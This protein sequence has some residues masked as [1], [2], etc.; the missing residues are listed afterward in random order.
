MDAPLAFIP[1]IPFGQ[2]LQ[3]LSTRR[4]LSPVRTRSQRQESRPHHT[5]C[6]T[7]PANLRADRETDARGFVLP[8]QG[9]VVVFQGRWP[10][11]DEAGLVES[12]Q[13]V[14]GRSAH[15]VDVTTLRRVSA[16]LFSIPRASRKARM[17]WMDVAEVRVVPD[18]Q[19]VSTQDAYR[20]PGTCDGYAPV[21][22][23]DAQEKEV[24]DAEY[25]QL[26]A[27]MVKST[28]IAAVV[29]SIL[30]ILASRLDV[31]FAYA[32]GASASLLYLVLLQ[33]AVDSVGEQS[34]LASRFLLLRFAVPA[35]PFVALSLLHLGVPSSPG[36]FLS[37]L[38]KPEA[39][40]IVIGLLTYKVPIISRTASE[41]VDGLADI[42]LGKTGMLGTAAA[43][44]A[45]QLQKKRDGSDDDS[46]DALPIFNP[47][48]I[49]GGPSGSGKGT[50][51]ALLFEQN[52]DRFAFSVSHT[53][54][55][56]REGEVNDR[57][58]SFV[59]I[60][61]FEQMIQDGKFIEYA[62]VHGQYY[63]TSIAAVEK[64]RA[65]NRV[66]VLDVDVQ[67]IE[68]I[69]NAPSLE[70]DARF[71]WVAPPSLDALEERLRKRGSETDQTIKTRLESAMRELTYAATNNVFDVIIVNDE[72]DRAYDEL[73]TFVNSVCPE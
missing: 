58:Y 60:E 51:M 1:T 66:C 61:Q 62:K 9:D 29:G 40:A 26:Q 18:A 54:R 55:A 10:S 17:R 47:T 19:Y 56:M 70:L 11:E 28:A 24:I 67:G 42:E 34:S 12:V 52:A 73:R 37:S 22:K 59:S 21:A 14:A 3:F 69:R 16:D 7:T 53:T 23:I 36:F 50:L 35:L 48:L 25:R 57:D 31:S 5:R 71:I 64:V 32:L 44:T 43:L 65:S 27:S 15:I 2:P 68:A 63:G 41:F 30:P 45:R 20:I 33:R 72:L 39:L 38:S 46:E 4:H 49:F 6:M 8:Q 13:F